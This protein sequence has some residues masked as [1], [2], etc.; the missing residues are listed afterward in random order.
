MRYNREIFSGLWEISPLSE[1]RCHS[2]AVTAVSAA[3][4]IGTTAYA[5]S[6]K[7]EQ[8]D[9]AAGSKELARTN[10]KL[11]PIQRQIEAAAALGK[12]DV[13]IS[14]PGLGIDGIT[15][16]FNGRGTADVMGK[17]AQD[18]AKSTL[19][20]QK[21]YDSKFIDEAKKQQ[22]LA[23]PEG[24]QARS[25]MNE[26]IQK[27]IADKPDRPIADLLDKQIGEELAASQAGKLDPMMKGVLDEAVATSL[28]DRGGYSPQGDFEEPLVTGFEGEGRRQAGIQKAMSWLSSGAT[29]EDTEYRRSQQ[30]MANLSAQISGTTPQSQFGSL[31]GAQQGA[32]PTGVAQA[33]LSQMPNNAAQGAAGA[34]N[35]YS[36]KLNQTPSW[37]AGLSALLTAGGAAAKGTA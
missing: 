33:N 19:E 24:V 3:V 28:K 31:S 32:T 26:L 29:P 11:L 9:L 13:T 8:P 17:I 1:T 35:S 20:L 21:K 27:Q 5:A 7:P 2:W 34:V 4:A 22:A 18:M 6:S 25:K 23:D 37:M 36:A 30:N 14:A 12:K 16:H 10:A 15:Y